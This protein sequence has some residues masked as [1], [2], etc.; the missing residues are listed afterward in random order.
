M[1]NNRIS[2]V[3]VVVVI[4]YSSWFTDRHGVSAWIVVKSGNKCVIC[5]AIWS[6]NDYIVKSWLCQN[7]IGLMS[8]LTGTMVWVVVEHPII[9]RRFCS[10]KP[11]SL[12]IVGMTLIVTI[13]ENNVQRSSHGWNSLR[14]HVESTSIRI[15]ILLNLHA[16]YEFTIY[17]W[18][19]INQQVISSFIC[20]TQYS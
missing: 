19:P 12:L 6:S 3:V 2:V 17:R 16:I 8:S 13:E 18:I 10:Y 7:W 11:N 20:S 9:R 15:P 14:L 4:S 5:L 1:R